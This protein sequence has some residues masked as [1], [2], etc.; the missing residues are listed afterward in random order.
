MAKKAPY[1]ELPGSAF[2][3][4]AHHPHC[5]RHEA[6]LL[7][8]WTRPLCLGC[9]CM[10]VGFLLGMCI[11][12]A[13]TL[14][15][16]ALPSWLLLHVLLVSPTAG[17]PWIQAK[18]FKILA[19]TALGL[20]SATWLFGPL[21]GPRLGLPLLGEFAVAGAVMGVLA[22]GLL[23]LRERRP[24]NPCT[25]CPLGTYPTCEWNLPRILRSSPD[26]ELARALVEAKHPT[27]AEQ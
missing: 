12:L 25:A 3:R 11:S 18:P 8:F 4:G 7:W 10:G 27:Q 5:P 19:R 20:A 22:L 14:A 24:S 6:H 13:G 15:P 21:D 17:Q 9:T 23:R 2:L 16:L 26:V 1:P